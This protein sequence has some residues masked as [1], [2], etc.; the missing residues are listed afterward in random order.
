MT[1]TIPIIFYVS[2]YWGGFQGAIAACYGYINTF[3][4]FYVGQF[5]LASLAIQSRFYE[6]NQQIKIPVLS[7]DIKT[8]APCNSENYRIGR[9]YHKLCD[10]IEIINETFTAHF[11]FLFT[12]GLVRFYT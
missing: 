6:L 3:R 4:M 11:I 5:I 12:N 9:I 10:G 1:A 2:G 7:F 8:V